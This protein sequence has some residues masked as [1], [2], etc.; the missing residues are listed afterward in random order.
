MLIEDLFAQGVMTMGPSRADPNRQVGVFAPNVVAAVSA[1]RA[2]EIERFRWIVGEWNYENLVPQTRLSPA[3]TDIGRQRF[4]ITEDGWVSMVSP[5]DRQHRC[6]TF[7]PFS[8]QW[9]YV[10]TRGS[11][12]MLRSK[13]GWAG[14][15]I[16]FVGLMTM[17]GVECE[18]RMT[19]TKISE[20]EFRFVNEERTAEGAW[21]YIDEWH[22]RSS[23][24][25]ESTSR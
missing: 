11:Y 5:D 13:Q 7:D 23:L 20:T 19:W 21:V 24:S 1:A 16:T 4:A 17:I 2:A 3:Y 8:G 14:Q 22:F 10:L 12:G 25:A 9:I 15:Q 6:L 18:W